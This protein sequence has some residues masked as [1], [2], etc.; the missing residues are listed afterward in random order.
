[1][2]VVDHGV[3]IGIADAGAVVARYRIA[4]N[5][6]LLGDRA[7]FDL[8]GQDLFG[9]PRRLLRQRR[10][11]WRRCGL[12]GRRPRRRRFGFA[13]WRNVNTRV[14]FVLVVRALLTAVRHDRV[15]LCRGGVDRPR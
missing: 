12:R 3:G 9:L 6:G 4:V 15:P 8:A 1:V 10:R 7:A 5:V 2:I 11:G 13:R 14:A